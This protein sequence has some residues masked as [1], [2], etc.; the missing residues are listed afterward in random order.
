MAKST[1]FVKCPVCS[2][3]F[4]DWT[5]NQHIEECL[6]RNDNGLDI[7]RADDSPEVNDNNDTGAVNKM[8]KST[9]LGESSK[10][11]KSSPFSKGRKLFKSPS[12]SGK[13]G[14]GQPPPKRAKLECSQMSLKQSPQESALI[15]NVREEVNGSAK[16]GKFVPLAERLRPRT[17]EQYVGQSQILGDKSMLKKLLEADEIPSMIFWGPPGCGKVV[18]VFVVLK[19]DCRKG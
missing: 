11:I 12:E 10:T 16:R 15:Q 4:V 17:L 2:G 13:K 6:K 8:P 7:K 5:I 3:R 14:P 18:H 9:N 19:Q 1:T